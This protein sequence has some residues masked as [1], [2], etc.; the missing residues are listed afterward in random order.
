MGTKR[1]SLNKIRGQVARARAAYAVQDAA[2]GDS[3]TRDVSATGMQVDRSALR[4]AQGTHKRKLKYE[5]ALQEHKQ[6]VSSTVRNKEPFAPGAMVY[7]Y[8]SRSDQRRHCTPELG[9]ILSQ[10]RYD[11]FQVMVDGSIYFYEMCRM[12]PVDMFD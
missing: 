1:S 11:S 6:V 9:I 8:K 12:R 5:D 4:E 3:F 7:V 10:E 2:S